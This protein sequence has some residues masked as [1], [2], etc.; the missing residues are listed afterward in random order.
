MVVFKKIYKRE[1]LYYCLHTVIVN[2]FCTEIFMSFF[3]IFI[4]CQ[5]KGWRERNAAQLV[6]TGYAPLLYSSSA[7]LRFQDDLRLLHIVV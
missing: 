1:K 2:Q 3:I 7:F 6:S 5:E 4:F